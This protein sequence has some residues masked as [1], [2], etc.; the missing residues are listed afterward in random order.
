M[1]IKKRK[2]GKKIEDLKFSTLKQILVTQERDR[3]FNFSVRSTQTGYIS[4]SK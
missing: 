2:N 1:V 3:A 4:L